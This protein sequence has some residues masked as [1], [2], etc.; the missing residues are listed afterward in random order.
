M[1]GRQYIN[2][3]LIGVWLA[4][5]MDFVY[6]GSP[7]WTFAP[8]T[9]TTLTVA[10]NDTAIISY[11]VTNQSKKSHTLAMKG[12]PGVTQT[13]GAGN[14][15][16][17]FVLGYQQSCILNLTVNGSALKGNV[18][19][20]PVVCSQGNPNQCY[21]PSRTNILNI[22]KGPAIDYTVGGS[23]FGLLGTVVLENNGSDLLSLNV[24][25]TFNFS[26]ALPPGS[27][28]LVTVQ[29]QPAT[30]TCTLSNASG[31]ITNTSITN[32]MVN[33]STNTR[34]VGGSV[35]GLVASESVVLQNNG[36]DDLLINSNGQFIFSMPVTQGAVYKVTV[37]TQPATQTCTV[38]NS[39]GTVGA[40]N[41]TNV[42]VSC[43]TN[44]YTVGGTVSG[45]SGTVVLQDNGS[46]NV[47]INSNGPFRFAT[48]VAQGAPYNVSVLTQPAT[49]T[50]SVSNGS[51][52]MGGANVTNIGVNC[53]TNTTRLNAS[54]SDLALSV[55]GLTEYGVNGTP[56]SGLARMITITNTGNNPAIN[57]SI[58]PPTWPAGTSNTTSCGS[59]LSANSSCTITIHPGSTATSDGTNPCSSG[60]APVPGVVQ[61]SAG[62]ATTVST[63]VVVLSYGCIYQ[64]GYVYAF[65]DTTSNT[66]S[67][68]G[69][70]TTTSDQAAAYPNGIVWS[71][72]GGTGG[73][74]GGFDPA[75]VSYDT[76]PGI[77]E[78]STSITASPTYTTFAAFFASTYIN[79][80]PFIPASF[81][82][83]N[84][85]F[86]GFCNTDN[87]LTFYNQFITNNTLGKGGATPFLASS[88]P[89]NVV[90]Y[91]AGLCKQAIA[92]YSDWYLPAICEM[93]YGN[94]AC[95]TSGAP[96]QQNIQ[97]SLIDSSGF[98]LPS[99]YYW[100]STEFSQAPKGFAG[101]QLFASGGSNNQGY[102]NKGIRLG[103]R[104]S[105][106]F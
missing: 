9:A 57:L 75:D 48:P 6:A 16:N 61:V 105:R 100:S 52:S 29:R 82:R 34:T 89:T 32:V 92:S 33:C 46:D 14:C 83:C 55:S 13:K 94:G 26:N 99:G 95:G 54:V 21:Q 18:L 31:T 67:V 98:N 106:R 104:C 51:G 69:K 90:Y 102:S 20:G 49:Q 87:I 38:T 59:T 103:V 68:G 24:D 2:K 76:L 8:L 4:F 50:C 40:S 60:T 11:Q 28:Y 66:V 23:I 58:T 65:D 15:S 7:L 12:I 86:D 19:G 96:M 1:N 56:A 3:I 84:G 10:A 70:V 78:T 42:Q 63:S 85:S 27:A 81:S 22:T 45:L 93:G 25:G 80:N 41:I 37:L 64:G 5:L 72:N 91:A 36:G 77:D 101:Y 30:Q 47:T 71:S 79:T 44:A 88:G 74:S 73:G 35:S 62:N 43:S 17:P 39:S 53:V 97:S